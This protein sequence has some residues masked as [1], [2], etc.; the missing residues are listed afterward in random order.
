MILSQ[1]GI[2]TVAWSQIAVPQQLQTLKT[3][4]L[5]GV[6]YNDEVQSVKEVDASTLEPYYEKLLTAYGTDTPIIAIEKFEP[7]KVYTIEIDGST[8]SIDPRDDSEDIED[9]L[10]HIASK[11]R[12]NSSKQSIKFKCGLKDNTPIAMQVALDA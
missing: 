8:I 2:P 7:T 3:P 12:N 1:L 11:V 10:I 4:L 6:L 9:A 5:L